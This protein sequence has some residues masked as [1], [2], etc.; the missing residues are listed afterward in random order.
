MARINFTASRIAA[1]ECEAG[2]TQSFLWDEGCRWLALRATR[3]GA[4]AYIFQAKLH[5]KDIRVTIGSPDAWKIPDARA[6]ANELKVMVDKGIDPRIVAAET[7][8]Q[9]KAEA[10][11]K[12]ALKLLAREAW[13]AYLAAPHPKWGEIHRKAHAEAAQE[14]GEVL[15]SRKALSR[16]GPLA[17]LL[18]LPLHD[19]TADVVADW[20]RQESATRS[21]AAQNGFRKFRA[22][23]NWCAKQPQY[24][25][26]IQPDCCQADNVKDV[27][28]PARA[29]KN[30]SL[31]K[32]QLALWFAHV[33]QASPVMSAFLQA[34]LLTGARR[35][36]MV[37]LKW[38]DVDFQWKTMRLPSSRS[39]D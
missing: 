33:R 6:R 9:A 34:L 29:R 35:N 15:K 22:F 24:R 39:D 31:Q 28:P 36:E 7:K 4:K 5:G 10:D 21:T 2:K 12:A 1:Y 14:G 17:P 37:L 32:D 11:E 16:P 30:D 38:S 3:N 20:L 25:N 8:Q 19:I 23:V 26:A 18:C 13:N 27:V